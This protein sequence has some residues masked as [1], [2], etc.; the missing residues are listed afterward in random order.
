MKVIVFFETLLTTDP[1]S[2]LHPRIRETSE[3]EKAGRT[4]NTF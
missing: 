3:K 4:S 2:D 1:T